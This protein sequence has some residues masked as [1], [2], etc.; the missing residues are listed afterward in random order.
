[1]NIFKNSR[2]FMAGFAGF[3]ACTAIPAFAQDGKW[4]YDLSMN[5]WFNDTTVT[6]DTPR[7]E[8]EAELSF[9]DAIEDLDFAFMGTAEARNGPWVIIDWMHLNA[10][11]IVVR[12]SHDRLSIV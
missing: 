9:S 12:G 8:V 7:G 11:E 3:L 2:S 5:L 10:G 6:T 1:M 4:T